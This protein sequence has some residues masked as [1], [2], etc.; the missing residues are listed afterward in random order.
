MR[1]TA[2]YIV[3]FSKNEEVA[4]KVGISDIYNVFKGAKAYTTGLNYKQL[5][6]EL[7]SNDREKLGRAAAFLYRILK[8][9]TDIREEETPVEEILYGD[10]TKYVN[11]NI[12]KLKD[13]KQQLMGIKGNTL[14][15][16]INKICE[17][18]VHGDVNVKMIIEAVLDIEKVTY[19]YIIA[20]L[21]QA[22]DSNYVQEEDGET[23]IEDMN[24]D[25]VK[26]LLAIDIKVFEKWFYYVERKE[27]DE[28][29]YHTYHGTKGLEFENVLIVIED[30]FGSSAEDRVF[31]RKF[32]ENYDSLNEKM[33]IGEYKKARN[34]LYVVVTRAIKNLRVIYEGESGIVED[35]LAKIFI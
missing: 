17:C 7:L 18:Y 16:I 8:L 20:F 3:F 1:R 23:N 4:E 32:L 12:Q 5:N 35:I 9:Y 21:V 25:R 27:Q 34:L 28:I 11:L 14:G 24:L 29:V 31:I 30:G 26:Q 15:D 13:I 6:T 33:P 10:I 19:P 22:L 2:R